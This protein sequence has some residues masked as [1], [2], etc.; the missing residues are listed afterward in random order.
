MVNRLQVYRRPKRSDALYL[1]RVD[2]NELG[3]LEVDQ[4]VLPRLDFGLGRR[5][6]RPRRWTASYES[7]EGLPR[8]RRL[9]GEEGIGARR[10]RSRISIHLTGH[11]DFGQISC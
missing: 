5:E 3:V 10:H 1:L 11:S 2:L 7:V 9:K 8:H 6:H 4:T